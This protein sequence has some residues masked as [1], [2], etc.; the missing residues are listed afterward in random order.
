MYK[1]CAVEKETLVEQPPNP[2]LVRM[3]D[4]LLFLQ[5][6]PLL[7]SWDFKDIVGNEFPLK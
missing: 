1:T 4:L 2:K 6:R 5:H 3:P 7:I